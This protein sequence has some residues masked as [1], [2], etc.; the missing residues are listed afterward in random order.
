MTAFWI[1]SLYTC[2]FF[3]LLA[4]LSFIFLRSQSCLLPSA[5]YPLNKN[6]VDHSKK[7]V[8]SSMLKQQ[9]FPAIEWALKVFFIRVLVHFRKLKGRIFVVHIAT[10]CHNKPIRKH[11][12]SRVTLFENLWPFLRQKCDIL[13]YQKKDV[14]YLQSLVNKWNC[15]R[16]TCIGW[17]SGGGN[18]LA[19]N[20]FLKVLLL[21]IQ[22]VGLTEEKVEP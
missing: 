6:K 17:Q 8:I 19:L 22:C 18:R 14:W 9:L 15:Q 4:S 16:N 20:K 11:S 5:T 10:R 12:R 3:S 13:L 1:N 2:D 21:I 7:E